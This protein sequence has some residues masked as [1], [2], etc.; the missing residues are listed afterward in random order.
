M[1]MSRTAIVGIPPLQRNPF[2]PAVSR[3]EKAEFCADKEQIWINVIFGNR[4]QRTALRQIPADR[5]PSF[6]G[7]GA[8]HN[9]RF[10]IAVLMI[11][12]KWHKPC[13]HRAAKPERGCT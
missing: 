1:A 4:I 11:V 10:E 9:I 13:L 2:R 3:K 7:I 8:F 6:S 5:N 12:E